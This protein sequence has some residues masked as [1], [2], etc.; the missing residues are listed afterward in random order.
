MILL[1]ARRSA[2]AVWD[3]RVAPYML[4]D[5]YRANVSRCHL[6]SGKGGSGT[7][8]DL[9]CGTGLPGPLCGASRR[10]TCVC[11]RRNGN[12]RD[13]ARDC[14]RQMG[15]PIALRD[16]GAGKD[17]SLEQKVDVIVHEIIET[18]PRPAAKE[19]ILPVIADARRFLADGG[20]LIPGRLQLWAVGVARSQR[21][22]GGPR[23]RHQLRQFSRYVRT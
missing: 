2:T 14:S 16:H 18:R 21:P 9:G 7:V 22:L 19:N 3:H 20:I 12:R 10:S 6:C 11:N 15:W 8:L 17:V 13:R 1:V 4:S 23:P 5:P